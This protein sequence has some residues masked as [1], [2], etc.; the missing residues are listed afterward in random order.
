MDLT[1]E[2]MLINMYFINLSVEKAIRLCCADFK[3]II[4]LRFFLL[5]H[6]RALCKIKRRNGV[7]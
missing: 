2:L 4:A 3:K 1:P 5:L 6:G 7:V